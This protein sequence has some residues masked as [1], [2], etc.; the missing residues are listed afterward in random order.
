MT[1]TEITKLQNFLRLR[2]GTDSI[3]L[4]HRPEASDSVELMIDGE[5]FGA[6]YRDDDDGELCY[7]IQMTVLSE[8]IN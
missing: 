2:L 1:P 3:S 8:D 6:V 5:T 4:K 7:H